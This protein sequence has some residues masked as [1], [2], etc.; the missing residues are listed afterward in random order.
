[1]GVHI[2]HLLGSVPLVLSIPLYAKNSARI[3]RTTTTEDHG[4]VRS[5][6]DR[7]LVVRSFGENRE[8]PFYVHMEILLSVSSILCLPDVCFPKAWFPKRAFASFSNSSDFMVWIIGLFHINPS[9]SS[10]PSSSNQWLACFRI[11]PSKHW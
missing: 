2:N 4:S 7:R 5:A 8:R 3:E 10:S 1:M 11:L 9:S 6:C